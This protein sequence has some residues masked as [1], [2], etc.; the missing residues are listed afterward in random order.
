[1]TG[2]GHDC[3]IGNLTN[4]GGHGVGTQAYAWTEYA[5]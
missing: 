5:F 4:A 1:V 2:N 3:H